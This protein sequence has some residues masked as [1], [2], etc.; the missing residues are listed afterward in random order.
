MTIYTLWSFWERF[1]KDSFQFSRMWFQNSLIFSCIEK[2]PVR[3]MRG[4]QWFLIPYVLKSL[5]VVLVC[6]GFKRKIKTISSWKEGIIWGTTLPLSG[7]SNIFLN[8]KMFYNIK[9]LSP[10]QF[11]CSVMSDS[12]W[13]HGLQHARLPCPSPTPRA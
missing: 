1:F 5:K 10:V 13:L 9:N 2:E 12:L 7:S 8:D 6:S 11:S 3:K 4:C